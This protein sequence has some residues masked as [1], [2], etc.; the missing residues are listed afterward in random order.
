VLEGHA[1]DVVGVAI[2]PDGRR[3]WSAGA[4]GFLREWDV[5]TGA[6][7]AWPI[8]ARNRP[9]SA[10]G[11]ILAS[12]HRGIVKVRDL[13]AERDLLDVEEPG[14]VTALG[15]SRGARVL[16]ASGSAVRVREIA[17]GRLVATLET[18]RVSAIAVDG[19]RAALAGEDGTV[20]VWDLESGRVELLEAGAPVADIALEGGR[21][22]A[23]LADGRVRL[24]PGGTIDA[25]GGA[26]TAVALGPGIVATAGADGRVRV[27]DASGRRL[28]DA[29]GVATALYVSPDGRR[30]VS[31]NDTFVRLRELP[32]GATLAMMRTNPNKV[33]GT[34]PD[35][36][37][38][39]AAQDDFS[40]LIFEGT[41]PRAT[42]R[43]HRD[44][45]MDAALTPDGRHAVSGSQDKTLRLWDASTGAC[46]KALEGHTEGVGA[47]AVTADAGL[48][49][50]GT[51]GGENAVR[52]WDLRSGRCVRTFRG[53]AA[54]VVSVAVTPDG[55][56]AASGSRDRTVRIWDLGTGVPA[57]PMVVRPRHF[58]E[59]S[60]FE[61]R[62]AEALARAREAL[63]AGRVTE[64]IAQLDAARAVPGHERSP[65]ALALASSI[66]ARAGRGAFR[67]AWGARVFDVDAVVMASDGRIAVTGGADGG[68]R[69]W[70]LAEGRSRAL[71]E[72][73]DGP[74]TAVA[75]S[76]DARLAA[77]VGHDQSVR[78]WETSTGRGGRT[79]SGLRGR[80]ETAM[81]AGGRLF[82]IGFGE[83]RAWE[84]ETGRAVACGV[85]PRGFTCMAAT[86]DARV[87]VTADILHIARVWDG[88][89]GAERREVPASGF[90]VRCVAVT[91]D[92]RAV[93][94]GGEEAVVDLVEV[95]GGGRVARLEGHSH[96]IESIAF[97]GD[98]R[99]G[100]TASRDH[101]VR[102]WDVETRRA[103]AVLE[104]HGGEVASAALSAD[105][106]AAVSLGRDRTL[107]TWLIDWELRVS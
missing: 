19:D 87:L 91:P 4:D 78:L 9:R 51:G 104:G 56:R 35:G 28:H 70:D 16:S 106:R 43:G 82:A 95:A 55:R 39:L 45:I 30:L 44:W 8:F 83:L 13:A 73:H 42:L 52:V 1:R 36:R 54:V 66:A 32:S 59:I 7:A 67:G 50:T 2:A 48:A 14:E 12:T 98:G 99:V 76:P 5:E 38:N 27:W 63:E 84:V 10:D 11:N 57:P 85:P 60:R 100:L 80:C 46:L 69:L 94:V 65:E 24:W 97:S 61:R 74:V 68:V 3:A 81:F 41:G 21:V 102:L 62:F 92:G 25:H 17:T 105:A 37:F 20:R 34:T 26:V 90:A 93:A 22:A 49:V 15:M 72:R 33:F 86:P 77:S 47:V 23:G 103:L 53:H 64:A 40:V 96:W 18:G 29:E 31:R 79:L 88:A 6:S 71:A 101:T 89:T 58:E 75:L 107:R